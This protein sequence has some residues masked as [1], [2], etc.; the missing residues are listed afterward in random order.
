MSARHLAGMAA[1]LSLVPMPK[2]LPVATV[3]RNNS[4]PAF[5]LA[6]DLLAFPYRALPPP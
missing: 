4:S 2:P 3:F 5:L 1:L 6:V